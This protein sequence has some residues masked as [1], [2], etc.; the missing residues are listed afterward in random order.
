MSKCLETDWKVSWGKELDTN[1]QLPTA[2][3]SFSFLLKGCTKGCWN[4]W[5]CYYYYILLLLLQLL[6]LLL[7]SL[8]LLLTLQGR[9]LHQNIVKIQPCGT[10]RHTSTFIL[11]YIHNFYDITPSLLIRSSLI[12]FPWERRSGGKEWWKGKEIDYGEIEG[13]EKGGE[14]GQRIIIDAGE[15]RI[16]AKRGRKWQYMW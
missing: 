15:T 11:P 16:L 12:M 3:H 2:H 4:W 1:S 6:L 5:C 13:K 10:L 7:T 14:R 9:R 8:L